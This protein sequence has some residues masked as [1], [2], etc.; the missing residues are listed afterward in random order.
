[1]THCKKHEL[2]QQVVTLVLLSVIVILVFQTMF[3]CGNA[4]EAA[5]S[6]RI[7]PNGGSAKSIGEAGCRAC[8]GIGKRYYQSAPGGVADY[9]F[10]LGTNYG[11]NV[12]EEI[13]GN[14]KTVTYY[15]CYNCG[16]TGY[17]CK[18][19]EEVI[20]IKK[21]VYDESNKGWRQVDEDQGVASR[22]PGYVPIRWCTACGIILYEKGDDY[23]TVAKWAQ[24]HIEEAVT[25]TYVVY[26]QANPVSGGI[27]GDGGTFD[28]GT[29]IDLWYAPHNGYVFTGWS[30]A[31]V[32][33]DKHIVSKNV[34]ITANFAKVT[35]G[36]TQGITSTPIPTRAPLPTLA[37]TP[38]PTAYPLP[39]P[40]QCPTP[41]PQKANAPKPTPFAY[42][43]VHTSICYTGTQHNCTTSSCYTPVYHSHSSSCL[44]PEYVSG[45]TP[46]TNSSCDDGHVPV[47]C[48]TCSGKGTVKDTCPTCN[49]TN[50]INCPSCG[51]TGDD[52]EPCD[53]CGGDGKVSE[54]CGGTIKDTNTHNPVGPFTTDCEACT[55]GKCPTCNGAGTVNVNTQSG[56]YQ[57][58]CS[59][60]AGTKD[61]SNCSGVGTYKKYGC[62]CGAESTSGSSG[63]TCIRAYKCSTCG[64][65]ASSSGTCTK[66]VANK[67]TCSQCTNG[68]VTV[69]CST[70][71]GAG[72][73]ICN[74]S[75]CTGGKVSVDCY[76]CNGDKNVY[77][78]CS[79]CIGAG[80]LPVYSRDNVCGYTTSSIVDYRQICGKTNGAY[81]KNGTRVHAVCDKIVTKLTPL[82]PEQILER[83]ETPNYGA[84]STFISNSCNCGRHSYPCVHGEQPVK[85]V[86]CTASGFNSSLYNT[87]QTVTLSYGSYSDSAKNAVAKTTTIR[88]YVAADVTVTFDANGGTVSPTTKTVTYGEAYGTLPTPTRT[89]YQFNGWLYN[90]AIV[91]SSS[92]VRASTNHTLIAWWDSLERVVTFDPNGGTVSPTTKNVIYGEHYG[93]LPTPTR[94]GYTFTDWYYGPDKVTAS[95]IVNCYGHPTLIAGWTPNE[96]VITLNPN[97][98]ST[99]L[100]TVSVRYDATANNTIVT[101]A[102][103]PGYTIDGWYTSAEG[104]T[105]VFDA[106]GKWCQS[107]Y[108]NDGVWSYVG[109]VTLYA[110]WNANTYT[111]TLNGMGATNL[112]Q[113]STDIVYLKTGKN[114]KVPSKTGY[115]FE[116]FYMDPKGMGA[117]IFNSAGYGM[118][119]WTTPA[120][121]MVYANWVPIS[122]TIEVAQSEIRVDPVVIT[123]S[124]TITYDDTYTIPAALSDRHFT[125]SYELQESMTG[126]STPTIT[127]TTD[128][129]EAYHSFSGWQLFRSNG[130][131]YDYRKQYS[132]GTTVQFLTAVQ[133][134]VLTL[135]PYW[136]GSDATVDLPEPTCR[137]YNFLGWSLVEGDTVP[138]DLLYLEEDGDNT[139]KPTGDDTLYA[140]WRAKEYMVNLDGRGATKQEQTS[141]AA[142]YDKP[143]PDVV[144]PEKT[145]YVF[146]GYYTGVRGSGKQYYDEN[147]Y[148]TGD[149]TET[150]TTLYAC[151]RQ[152]D[153]EVPPKGEETEPDVLPETMQK[154][155][156]TSDATEIHLYAD[157]NN[158]STGALTDVQ[159]YQVSD[160]VIDG[161][162]EVAGAIPSTENVALRAKMGAWMF[163]GTLEQRSGLENVRVHV[164]VPYRTQ[165]EDAEDESLIISERKTKTIDIL[166][167]KAWSYWVFTEGGIYV[168]EKVRVENAALENGVVEVPVTWESGS[169]V[170]KPAYEFI[171]YGDSAERLLWN[172]YDADGMLSL[173]ITLS[174]EEYIIS[175]VPGQAPNVTEHLYNVCHKA[176]WSDTTRLLMKS[177]NVSVAGISML[178]N[179]GDGVSLDEQAMNQL[180]D[181][182]PQTSYTQIYQ[183]GIP[184]LA[185]AENG[186]HETTATVVYRPETEDEEGTEKRHILVTTANEIN[187]HT[188]VVCIPKI[189]ASHEDM[190]QCETI[191]EEYTVLVLDEEG[192]YSDFVIQVMNAGFHSDNKGY[193]DRDYTEYLLRKNGIEQNEVS[194]PFPVWLDVGNDGIHS[195]DRLIPAGEWYLLG[196]TEQR[197]YLPVNTK[198]GGYEITFR[199]VAV[200]GEGNEDK[201]EWQRNAQPAHYV[202]EEAI[203]IYVT[204]RLYDFMVSEVGGT[205]AWED[206]NKTGVFYTV[207]P[208]DSSETL[209]NTLPLREGVHPCYRNVGG[210][211]TGGWFR[212][213][214]T[215]IGR[216]FGTGSVLKIVP[217]IVAVEEEEY[218]EVDVYFDK[219][220][221]GGVFLRRWEEA[222]CTF[223]VNEGERKTEAVYQWEGIY[224]LPSRLYVTEKGT[225]VFGY[226]NR[227]GLNFSEDFWI[228][229]PLLMLRFALEITNA[230][231]MTLYYG[232]VPDY[233]SNNL[234]KMEAKDSYREDARGNRYE[235]S[236]GEVAIIYPGDTAKE[237]CVTNGI[238]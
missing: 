1:M 66:S 5:I 192:T 169:S 93:E 117:K 184:L 145:G 42:S 115:T 116:G 177:D 162:L 127:L 219:E 97:G 174:N 63:F 237:G 108:W 178:S 85:E 8:G 65:S 72:T 181:M 188:P 206:A 222:E 120:D 105:M 62:S 43:D 21:Y 19:Y 13:S 90:N 68:Q 37:P 195:N 103:Y 87:W 28:E 170:Q 227:Y 234:W 140:Y 229:E 125:V 107:V 10:G 123:K 73:R 57:E 233:V 200:N 232:M 238:Y 12:V 198:E 118:N 101:G 31:T 64:A 179:T 130:N 152:K 22:G 122:Y 155:E 36:P 133:G 161:V 80:Q 47:T 79:T 217:Q 89:N 71:S 78:K 83:G 157:D 7:C 137:G 112:P 104:G 56:Q 124:D 221:E 59:A 52:T 158:P 15:R 88:V 119:P 193:G 197:F 51:G 194:F 144:P 41:V 147:G 196:G 159:P 50:K 224:A 183:S 165:Y 70:C 212:F 29:T 3:F 16:D 148:G 204:G 95:T 182:I 167:P 143:V 141:V 207:G 210:V 199:S 203:K 45:Y 30:G 205:T 131:R 175:E 94:T 129:T 136:S 111:V 235:I 60:C 187:I 75:D 202:A 220:E 142:I 138:D 48:T 128:N 176:A 69:N 168:P 126:T 84:Y 109:N 96:Y 166:I 67:A 150:T 34:T 160:I 46:C 18:Q 172:S 4:A 216:S 163:A 35:A 110:H 114:V 102:N 171:T 201:S 92:T 228:K 61:C 214:V 213:C 100:Q 186:R 14:I 236:G 9:G 231:G 55:G 121:G 208:R 173:S 54:K 139:Y 58:R 215:S 146:Q 211:P 81:Y 230:Q 39:Y 24:Y 77:D 151:W 74:N 106:N 99:S 25:K 2:L 218:K 209:W 134:D 76:T 32:T 20:T 40:T 149:W 17:D 225:D 11:M 135:F 49:G 23:E 6:S 53:T 189:R 113:T 190:H 38:K 33:N 27:A 98:G 185:M 86:T 226:Q 156:V 180:R 164:T 91:T 82:F 153:V 132:A 223:F 44:G 154:I 191:P 26:V